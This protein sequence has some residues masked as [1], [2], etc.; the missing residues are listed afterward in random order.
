MEREFNECWGWSW[1]EFYHMG[2]GVAAV[3]TMLLLIIFCRSIVYPPT[4]K[5]HTK[6]KGNMNGFF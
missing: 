3:K 4:W 2:E 1:G 6:S 5:H